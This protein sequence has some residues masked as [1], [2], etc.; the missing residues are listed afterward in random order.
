MGV[1]FDPQGQRLACGTDR[2]TVCVWEMQPARPASQIRPRFQVQPET[3]AIWRVFFSPDGKHL[4]VCYD[5]GRTRIFDAA[6]GESV[7]T[8]PNTGGAFNLAF[9]GAG[10]YLATGV[11][12]SIAM[13]H[14]RTWEVYRTL[15]GHLSEVTSLDGSSCG[16]LVASSSADGSV[17]LWGLAS[18]ECLATLTSEGPYAGMNI[19]GV[20]GITAA[21]RATLVALSAIG[22]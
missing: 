1:A 15:E 22:D 17:R 5:G 11:E 9:V 18:G 13:R 8:L 7:F 12:N 2:G 3:R 19:T 10:Q 14:S 4:A 20:T 21:Q 16:E 6:T